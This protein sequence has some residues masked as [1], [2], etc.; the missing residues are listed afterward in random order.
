MSWTLLH[1]IGL[2][3]VLFLGVL[4][5][6]KPG[7]AP[8]V[9]VRGKVM[10]RGTTLPGGTIVF[11]PDASRGGSGPLAHAEIRADGSYTL[12]TGRSFGAVPGWHRVTVAAVRGTAVAPPRQRY[13]VPE[14]LVPDRYRDPQLSGLVCE[15]QA[16]RPNVLDFNLE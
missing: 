13:A 9:P 12:Q 15:V 4:A 6:C 14:S 8:L 16:D 10:Y 5:G 11:T 3:G 1:R 2:V 7:P